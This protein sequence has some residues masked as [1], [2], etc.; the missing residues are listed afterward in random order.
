M[1]LRRDMEA[2]ILNMDAADIHSAIQQNVKSTRFQGL[3]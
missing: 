1:I 3:H 2:P